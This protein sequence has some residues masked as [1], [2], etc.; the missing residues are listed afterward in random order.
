MRSNRRGND[1]AMN[2][3]RVWSMRSFRDEKGIHNFAQ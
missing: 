1:L 3:G 2:T